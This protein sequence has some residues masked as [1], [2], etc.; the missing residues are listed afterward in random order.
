MYDEILF[1]IIE[2]NKEE[3]KK[4]FNEVI[5]KVNQEIKLNILLGILVDFGKSY[6]DCYQVII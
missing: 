3:I 1:K 5:N 6:V 4:K 2:D